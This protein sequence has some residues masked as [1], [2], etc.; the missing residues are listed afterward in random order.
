MTK[1]E[2]TFFQHLKHSSS[3]TLETKVYHNKP[4]DLEKMK[5]RIHDAV[6]FIPTTV[7]ENVF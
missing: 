2:F 7:L 5:F 6:V 1:T 4:M 3:L